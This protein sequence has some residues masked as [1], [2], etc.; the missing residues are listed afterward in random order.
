MPWSLLGELSDYYFINYITE[1]D[2]RTN[3]RN[4]L[5]AAAKSEAFHYCDNTYKTEVSDQDRLI[6]FKNV[7][8]K[9]IP[10]PSLLQMRPR[11]S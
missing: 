11:K 5:C 8:F 9:N 1:E 6:S 4:V 3:N 7:I 10:I 2:C